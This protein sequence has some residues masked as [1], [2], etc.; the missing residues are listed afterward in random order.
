M[1]AIPRKISA[2]AVSGF[3]W[4]APGTTDVLK[5]YPTDRGYG[6]TFNRLSEDIMT[7]ETVE[8]AAVIPENI[9]EQLR[10]IAALDTTGAREQILNLTIGY[11]N[12]RT[13]KQ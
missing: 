7:I 3:M 2:T 8:D 6:S 11:D 5:W 10:E 13:S 1:S 9:P 4:A 12:K